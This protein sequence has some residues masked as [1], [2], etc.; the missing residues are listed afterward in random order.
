[1]SVLSV[2][3]PMAAPTSMSWSAFVVVESLHARISV[4]IDMD[5][6]GGISARYGQHSG[7]RVVKCPSVAVR[8]WTTRSSSAQHHACVSRFPGEGQP[9][10]RQELEY[11]VLNELDY[12]RVDADNPK[13]KEK[14]A[15]ACSPADPPSGLAATPPRR[16]KSRSRELAELFFGDP[17]S[18]ELVEDARERDAQAQLRRMVRNRDEGVYDQST[19]ARSSE[20]VRRCC[21]S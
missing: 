13:A 14:A 17:R 3:V 9:I 20:V 1:M 16:K 8:R 6:H 10:L 2:V 5:L 21:P 18:G 7:F 12:E 11:W 19:L 4:D 15:R